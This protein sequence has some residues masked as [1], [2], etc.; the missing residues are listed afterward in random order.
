MKFGLSKL[1]KQQKGKKKKFLK[2]LCVDPPTLGKPMGSDALAWPCPDDVLTCTTASSC[3][4]FSIPMLKIRLT[5]SNK[6]SEAW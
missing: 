2:E 4:Q 3:P 5:T 1:E 6:A